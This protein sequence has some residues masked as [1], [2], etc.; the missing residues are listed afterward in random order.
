MEL[1]HQ[2]MNSYNMM[3][4]IEQVTR[5]KGSA[6]ED[7]MP[8]KA[9]YG[10]WVTHREALTSS[11]LNGTY[12]PQAILGISIPKSNGKQR[13]LGVPTVIDRMLQQ[14]VSQQLANLFEFDFSEFSYGF[15]PNK[16]AQ[17]A[18]L[19]AQEHIQAGYQY[20]VDIDLQNFFDEVDHCILLQ[21]LY[22]K[23]KC[24]QTLRLIRKWLRAPIRIHGKLR[25]R[26]KGVPQGSPLSPILSNIML[27]ELDKELMGKGLRFVRYA[28][29]F[30]IYC[31]SA[32][33]ARKVGNQ[34]YVYLRDKLKLPINREKSGIRRPVTFTILGYGFVPTYK[35]GDRGGITN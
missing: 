8:V 29:D 13:L 22:R 6:G 4:A 14:A 28:D 20:I 23:V 7:G 2:V 25:K 10:Y 30:S 31:K 34:V 18:V 5:N 9:L 32:Y 15:R 12:L 27:N 24:Q 35:K 17:N 26:R 11:I 21:L 33:Q 3:R 19:K 1:I 16:R